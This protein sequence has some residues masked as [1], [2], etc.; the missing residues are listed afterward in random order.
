MNQDFEN[1]LRARH[2]ENKLNLN[3]YNSNIYEEDILNICRYI[4]E[5]GITELHI[6]SNALGNSAAI[7]LS[8]T[9]LCYLDISFNNI[10]PEG[11]K[12]FA[13]CPT[14]TTLII[15]D[16]ELYDLGAMILAVNP[17]IKTLDVRFNKIGNEGAGQLAQNKILL[18]LNLSSNHIKNDGVM[19]FSYNHTL[20]SLNLDYNLIQDKG[21]GKLRYNKTLTSLSMQGNLISPYLIDNLNCVI[22]KNKECARRR[23]LVTF[24]N[25]LRLVS[26]VTTHACDDLPRDMLVDIAVKTT[27]DDSPFSEEA[28]RRKMAYRFFEN[29][30]VA[31]IIPNE[32]SAI[33]PLK[34]KK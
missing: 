28:V 33:A 4:N 22:A 1:Q 21:A 15:G 29:P 8:K 18:S 20:L 27:S 7:A 6:Q 34:M 11:A 24:A 10:G 5:N 16:N 12:A 17:Y 30:T 32:I 13:K 23:A 25:M 19:P 31:S 14:L 26:H 3:D 9:K 2:T